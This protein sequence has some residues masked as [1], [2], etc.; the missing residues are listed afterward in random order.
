VLY[1]ATTEEKGDKQ[2]LRSEAPIGAFLCSQ[3]SDATKNLFTNKSKLIKSKYFL[4]VR[5][6]GEKPESKSARPGQRNG[7]PI[8][9]RKEAQQ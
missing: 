5:T 4:Y 6:Y 3:P 9:T 2:T 1:Q 7:H 8:K